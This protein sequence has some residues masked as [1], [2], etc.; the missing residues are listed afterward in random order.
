[1]LKNRKAYE[2]KLDAQLA[3]WK[4]DIDVMKAKTKRTG[5]DVMVNYDKAIDALDK[6][7]AEASKQLSDLKTA[8]DDAWENVKTGTEKVWSE[9]KSQ[10][11][12]SAGQA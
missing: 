10:F 7:H 5:V 9:I 3:Q 12:G 4:A 1:M 11:Q 2:T 6:K 8:T